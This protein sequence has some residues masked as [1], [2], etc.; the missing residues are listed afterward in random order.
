M[1]VTVER[2]GDRSV[3]EALGDDL[4]VHAALERQGGEPVAKIVD[5]DQRQLQVGD[6]PLKELTERIWL[7]RRLH[8]RTTRVNPR[9][10]AEAALALPDGGYTWRRIA[11][12]LPFER[13]RETR[14]RHTCSP[15]T[16]G[17]P[18]PYSDSPTA[19]RASD[20]LM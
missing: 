10:K 13:K 20:C 17:S 18:I 14:V 1:R 9:W 3:T 8:P 15:V 19:S 2:E 16:A 12:P 11:R 4:G 6:P 7:V 5:P